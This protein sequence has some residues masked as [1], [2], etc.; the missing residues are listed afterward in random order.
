MPRSQ[1]ALTE[2]ANSRSGAALLWVMAIGLFTLTIWQVLE[3]T[4]GRE[5]SGRTA[6][7]PPAG[8][9]RPRGRLSRAGHLAVA[10]AMGSGSRRARA[11]RR[12][13]R[14]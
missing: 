5:E 3:A 2:L 13:R 7:P 10:V 12:S 6:A 11:R 4:I 8:L 9:G 1:G 14:G